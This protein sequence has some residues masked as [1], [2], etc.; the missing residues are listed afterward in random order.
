MFSVI[1]ARSCD[2][3]LP[4]PLITATCQLAETI[5]HWKTV[6]GTEMNRFPS[7]YKKNVSRLSLF[8]ICL[9]G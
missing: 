6:I 3:V 7:C 8:R 1:A 2:S 4:R 9:P 5:V